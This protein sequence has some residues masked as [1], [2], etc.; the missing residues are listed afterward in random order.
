MKGVYLFVKKDLN[1]QL[2]SNYECYG[3]SQQCMKW[4][5]EEIIDKTK[6]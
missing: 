5:K 6:E 2:G 3:L 4:I 1:Q